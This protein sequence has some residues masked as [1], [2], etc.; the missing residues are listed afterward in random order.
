MRWLFIA[1][2]RKALAAFTSRLAL[3]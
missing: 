3:K 1:L 2:R